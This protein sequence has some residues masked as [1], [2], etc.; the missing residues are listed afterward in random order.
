MLRMLS[1]GRRLFWQAALVGPFACAASAV[2]QAIP[3]ASGAATAAP[4]VV[5]LNFL[6]RF[7]PLQPTFSSDMTPQE[8]D[9]MGRHVVY[10]T[11]LFNAGKVLVFGPVMSPGGGYEVAVIEVATREEAQNLIDNDPAVQS[12][13]NKMELAPMR[14]GLHR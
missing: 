1:K 14:V 7:V 11:A 10:W 13:L 2:A 4:A 6:V 12:G 8:R 9:L 5:K 3:G